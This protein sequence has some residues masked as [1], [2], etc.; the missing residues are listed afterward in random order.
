MDI[1]SGWADYVAEYE[2]AGASKLQ[3]MLNQAV[4]AARADNK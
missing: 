1:D 4:E 2:A 3:D